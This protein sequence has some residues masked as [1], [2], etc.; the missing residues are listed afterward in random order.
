MD[1]TNHGSCSNVVFTTEKQSMYKWTCA[2]HTCVVQE[3]TVLTC[4]APSIFLLLKPAESGTFFFF[5]ES[6]T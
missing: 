6:G 2:V 1:S 5:F 4:S 3:S